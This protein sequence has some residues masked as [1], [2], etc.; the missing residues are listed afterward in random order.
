M[1]V[2]ALCPHIQPFTLERDMAES[3][4]GETEKIREG[5]SGDGRALAPN[6]YGDRIVW[7]VEH[8]VVCG[9]VG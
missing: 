4:A 5:S 1:R 9:S 7:G 3:D 8:R 6:G 2:S